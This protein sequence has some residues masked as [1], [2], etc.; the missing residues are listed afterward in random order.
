MPAPQ[1]TDA[2]ER[3]G[4]GV[5]F[6]AAAAALLTHPIGDRIG[7]AEYTV[8]THQA[9]VAESQNRSWVRGTHPSLIP[10]A[11]PSVI[12]RS[13]FDAPQQVDSGYA[14]FTGPTPNTASVVV[15]VHKRA[16]PEQIDS[17][18][19]HLSSY[20][21]PSVAASDVRPPV[22]RTAAPEQIDTA[23][24]HVWSP[25]NVQPPAPIGGVEYTV[26]THRDA[27]ASSDGYAVKFGRFV[28]AAVVGTDVRIARTWTAAP[29]QIESGAASTWGLF[30]PAVADTPKPRTKIAAPQFVDS[31]YAKVSGY[32]PPDVWVVAKWFEVEQESTEQLGS[33]IWGFTPPAAA[34]TDKPPPKTRV[35]APEQVDSGYVEL[36]RYVFPFV[37]G[38]DP[39]IGQTR[40]GAP[41]QIESGYAVVYG[42]QPASASTVVQRTKISAPEQINSGD[43][44]TWGPYVV[45]QA[46]GRP[47]FAA[48]EQIESGYASVWGT[49]E[50]RRDSRVASTL[51]AV[52][53]SAEGWAV[54]WTAYPTVDAPATLSI[55]GHRASGADRSIRGSGTETGAI[56][57]TGSE[58]HAIR[59]TGESGDG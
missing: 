42:P 46:P 38:A 51:L 33:A 45:A 20:V 28:V 52:P 12:V 30:Q 14:F 43:A 31:A 58:V 16:G 22:T 5:V 53:Q 26:G 57:G 49:F 44:S 56:R 41:E 55:V 35:A 1:Q 27:Y 9:A 36:A 24:A 4:Y 13:F 18:S 34:G 32:T 23:T 47:W 17:G 54:L 39:K 48:P 19:A 15:V 8:G 25:A 21:Y 3:V 6:A 11:A 10:A 50:P 37:P 7:V 59:G 40:L 2:Q 29:D